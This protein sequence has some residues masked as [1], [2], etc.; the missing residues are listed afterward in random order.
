MGTGRTPFLFKVRVV[1]RESAAKKA[2][3]EKLDRR[4]RRESKA[5]PDRRGLRVRKARQEHRE[6]KVPRANPD[7]RV[8]RGCK[9]NAAKPELRSGS[10]PPDRGNTFL[11]M[12]M[13]RRT[14]ASSIRTPDV[15]T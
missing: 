11:S 14:S 12:T 9:V 10:M 6:I 5:N 1:F 4:V 8:L 13:K 2:T 3:P 15:F 7:R